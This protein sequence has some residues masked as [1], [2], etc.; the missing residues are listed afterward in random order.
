MLANSTSAATGAAARD[1]I[2][3]GH[4]KT[5]I[6]QSSGP[7][8]TEV[9]VQS[10]SHNRKIPKNSAILLQTAATA[11]AA[12]AVAPAADATDREENAMQCPICFNCCNPPILQCE[13][14][15]SFCDECIVPWVE[16]QS[17]CAVCR[18]SVADATKVCYCRLYASQRYQ[19]LC[20]VH[21]S[22]LSSRPL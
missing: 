8:G 13:N 10:S 3:V 2:G 4:G 7:D 19:S 14:G 21:S 17:C 11:E 12:P 22:Q 15:H 1:F 5:V 6:T 9:F 20:E 18:V 16:E